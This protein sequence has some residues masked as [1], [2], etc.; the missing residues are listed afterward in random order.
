LGSNCVFRTGHAHRT[1]HG[2]CHPVLVG[3]AAHYVRL[4]LL[5]APAVV[6]LWYWLRPKRPLLVTLLTLG[7][8]AYVL[9]GM[10]GAA[11]NAVVW[12]E[13]MTEYAGAGPE[14]L[15]VL[16]TVFSTFATTIA[17]GVWGILNRI[18]SG[19]WWIGI[20]ALLRSERRWLGW[21]TIV[22]GAFSAIAAV[23]NLLVVAPLTGIGTMGFLLLAP[24]WALWLGVDLWRQPVD[25][26]DVRSGEPSPAGAEAGR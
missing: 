21:F 10:L 26:D 3:P 8:L 22:L 12:P 23:G 9:L 6:F 11:I 25:S 18:V 5:V 13:L 24:A 15:A 7:G 17:V 19:I 16:E 1:R 2:G 4:L 20:G 14:R